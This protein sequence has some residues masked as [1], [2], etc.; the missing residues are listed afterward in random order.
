VVKH[1]ER[2]LL[3]AMRLTSLASLQVV[4]F[5]NLLSPVILT[6]NSWAQADTN[7]E[8]NLKQAEKQKRCWRTSEPVFTSINITNEEV[9]EA[10]IARQIEKLKDDFPQ[11]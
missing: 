7:G 6:S 5:A 3:A 2:R 4:V 11:N 8:K 1:V 10:E 9:E